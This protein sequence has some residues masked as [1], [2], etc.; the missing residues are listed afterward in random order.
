MDNRALIFANLLNGVSAAQ[1]AQAFH[2]QSED[3]VLQIFGFIL[4]KIKSYCFLRARQK[5]A[6][7][8]I[9]AN[10]VKTAQKYRLTCLSVLPKLNIDKEPQFRDIHNE[11]VNHDNVMVIGKNLSA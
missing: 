11:I 1:V 6:L 2:K 3:E 5:N 7:P 9:I 10:D 8:L 4:R